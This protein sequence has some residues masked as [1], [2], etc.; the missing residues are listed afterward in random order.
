[1]PARQGLPSVKLPVPATGVSAGRKMLMTAA[2]TDPLPLPRTKPRSDSFVAVY[3][4]SP[5]DPAPAFVT[6]ALRRWWMQDYRD[7]W[8]AKT[9]GQGEFDNIHMAP[10]M[11]ADFGWA[12]EWTFGGFAIGLLLC[13]AVAPVE[14]S[15]LGPDRALMSHGERRRRS[16]SWG[17]HVAGV[18]TSRR[19]ARAC[20][21]RSRCARVGHRCLPAADRRGLGHRP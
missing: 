12:P 11:T 3:P 13:G 21:S 4:W 16:R 6:G 14:A 8:V 5:E 2:V 15:L 7:S 17:T 18:G 9:R 19:P 1:M 20:P 10:R